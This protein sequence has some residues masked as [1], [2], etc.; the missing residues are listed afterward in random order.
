MA[1]DAATRRW[2]WWTLLVL[3][4]ALVAA[5]VVATPWS[6]WPGGEPLQ[7]DVDRDFSQRQIAKAA[8]F[9]DQLR[10]PAYLA[11]AAGLAGSVVL[12]LTRAGAAV[13]TAMRSRLRAWPVQVVFAAGAVTL[14]VQLL[15]LPFAAWSE[16]V[17][18]R[19][20]LSTQT[21]ASWAAD[22]AKTWAVTTVFAAVGLLMVV[23]LARRFGG[24]WFLP[25][26]LAGAVLL[27]GSSYVYPV[28]VEPLFN[29]FKPM[30]SGPLK[31]SL[32]DLANRDGVDVDEVLVADASQRTTM[33]NAYVSGFGSTRRI[34]VYDT[35]LRGT[36]AAQVRLVVAHELGHADERDVLVGSS[37]AA[38]GTAAAIVALALLLRSRALLRRAGARSAGDPAVVALVLALAGVAALLAAPLQ[39]LL[40]R[41]IEARADVHALDL[42]RDPATFIAMQRRLAR[43]NLAD[44]DPPLFSYLWFASH[45]TP[46]ERI[47][48]AR[49]WSH[50]NAA[51]LPTPR[52]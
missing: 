51:T 36:P 39:N 31:T 3:G 1:D 9:H 12:G 45:P 21:W 17:L 43:T 52:P 29:D 6:P 42:T 24:W 49:R 44:L 50:E 27:L 19:Y 7:A 40:S 26:A 41:H 15:Q 11:L 16:S 30:A 20:G 35:L 38:L 33:L 48:L 13:V 37:I 28:A 25:G 34:V 18:R 32:L 4:L 22:A 5:A 47:A 46:P 2:A 14:V 23:G 10:L 8:T